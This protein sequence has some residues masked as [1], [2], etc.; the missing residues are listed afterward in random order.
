VELSSVSFEDQEVWPLV[1]VKVTRVFLQKQALLLDT[2][3]A[4]LWMDH[5]MPEGAPTRSVIQNMKAVS[6]LHKKHTHT[7]V[8]PFT[9][10]RLTQTITC[11][12]QGD[13]LPWPTLGLF[14][15]NGDGMTV[16]EF[17]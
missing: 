11:I 13:E 7:I 2:A 14:T 6:H 3:A 15:Q 17:N 1:S 8:S 12:S 4:P 16:A 5:V 10:L 9:K